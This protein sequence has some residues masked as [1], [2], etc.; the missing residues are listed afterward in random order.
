M[1]ALTHKCG[2]KRI[3]REVFVPIL[4]DQHLILQLDREV[5]ANL[6]HKGFDSKGHAG[7]QLVV[8]CPVDVFVW[9]GDQWPL[10]A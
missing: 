3:F 1:S 4:S 10:V 2:V 7:L 9:I 6:T 5:A 8:E